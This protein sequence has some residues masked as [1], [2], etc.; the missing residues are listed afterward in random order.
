MTIITKTT[1]TFVVLH[2]SD[3]PIVDLDIAM[4]RS[5][6]DN[7]VGMEEVISVEEVPDDQVE[8]ELVALG[9]DGTF[10]NLE[11]GKEEE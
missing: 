2:P 6:T 1:F 4:A 7:A 3:D 10:F 8:A 5:D 9:N 11:L